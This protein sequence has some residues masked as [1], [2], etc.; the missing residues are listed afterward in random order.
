[1]PSEYVTE[2]EVVAS[3]HNNNQNNLNLAGNDEPSATTNEYMISQRGASNQSFIYGIANRGFL[4]DDS[5][6]SLGGSGT[7][8]GAFYNTP[9]IGSS[10]ER[11]STQQQQQLQQQT[12]Q[13]FVSTTVPS[14]F[15]PTLSSRSGKQLSKTD[16]NERVSTTTTPKAMALST[17]KDKENEIAIS[18]RKLTMLSPPQQTWKSPPPNDYEALETNTVTG[19]FFHSNN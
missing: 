5:H 14:S 12:M 7:G 19:W 17:G 13:S 10:D 11:Q 3:S 4:E 9:E 16:K 6:L 8:S 15:R 18:V 2:E 1:M